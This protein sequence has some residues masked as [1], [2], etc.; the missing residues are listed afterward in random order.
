MTAPKECKWHPKEDGVDHINTASMGATRLGCRLSNFAYTPVR[1]EGGEFRCLEG[2]WYWLVT[3]SLDT[4]WDKEERAQIEELRTLSGYKAKKLGKA[5]LKRF[6]LEVYIDIVKSDL[7]REY[8]LEAAKCK[9]RQHPGI[10]SELRACKLPIAH[11][12][13]WGKLD[14]CKVH[15]TGDT[16]WL[17]NAYDKLR[18]NYNEDEHILDID[19]VDYRIGIDLAKEG[20]KDESV[21]G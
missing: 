11:Y 6:P 9:L 1:L 19:D 14:N 20:T 16:D 8:F 10:L 17:W 3:L 15:Y 13:Y 4:G 12:M 5:L 2:Y 18:D 21:Q 7:F